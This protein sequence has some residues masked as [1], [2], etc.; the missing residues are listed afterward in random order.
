MFYAGESHNHICVAA[1]TL[2]AGW[3]ADQGGWG[4]EGSG[5][6][7]GRKT[8]QKAVKV[9]QGKILVARMDVA[10]GIARISELQ[11]TFRG[12]ELTASEA[13]WM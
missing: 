12:P 3:R 10:A 6:P 11:E 1:I 2:A 8:W 7:G 5:Q 9:I 4:G 13:T